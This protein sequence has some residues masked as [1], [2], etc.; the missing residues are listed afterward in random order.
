M[1]TLASVHRHLGN[2]GR[3]IAQAAT[4][5]SKLQAVLWATAGVSS[6]ALRPNFS[7][8][9]WGDRGAV[10]A[11]ARQGGQVQAACSLCSARG[12]GARACVPR[13]RVWAGG[14]GPGQE[15]RRGL[16]SKVRGVRPPA[17]SPRPPAA[18]SAPHFLPEVVQEIRARPGTPGR[19]ACSPGTGGAAIPG[20]VR[21]L[22]AA[23]GS[24]RVP[25]ILESNKH[26][27]GDRGPPGPV[28]G[29]ASAGPPGPPGPRARAD[30]GGLSPRPEWPEKLVTSGSQD[31]AK[32][33]GT[34]SG[35]GRPPR[36]VSPVPSPRA[37]GREDSGAGQRRRV[38][39][40][41]RRAR[42]A[43]LS[44]PQ[45]LRRHASTGTGSRSATSG[46]ARPGPR[47]PPPRHLP[48]P[49]SPAPTPL[50]F[51]PTW[52][53]GRRRPATPPGCR[54][55]PPSC[56]RGLQTAPR[57]PLRAPE[58]P[59]P[60]SAPWPRAPTR[61]RPGSPRPPPAPRTP[62][63]Q[64]RR[65][66]RVRH[67]AG[68]ARRPGPF[69][70]HPSP[71]LRPAPLREPR[72]S[73][74]TSPRDEGGRGARRRGDPDTQRS[75]DPGP[76]W[77]A[78]GPGAAGPG[79]G[80]RRG[81]APGVRAGWGGV[82]PRGEEAGRGGAGRGGA[83]RPRAALLAGKA[84]PAAAARAA[85]TRVPGAR[86][87]RLCSPPARRGPPSPQP[88]PHLPRRGAPPGLVARPGGLPAPP[89]HNSGAPPAATPNFASSPPVRANRT[90]SGHPSSERS[91]FGEG[92]G[93]AA[94][95]ASTSPAGA[96]E[97]PRSRRSGRSAASRTW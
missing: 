48:G 93:S 11:A 12:R 10:S 73:G 9:A 88:G 76:G 82:A 40:S 53:A 70:P 36:R 60:R 62:Y 25:S 87:G 13:S 64:P 33:A 95:A 49:P 90:P 34:V 59:E 43:R 65:A 56:P 21:A 85:S 30:R 24:R 31:G 67:V 79:G 17:D 50:S 74:G 91:P 58:P 46:R 20:R 35:A 27:L 47:A 96:G 26:G 3:N 86:S 78:G 28:P 55:T 61:P 37:A 5:P 52:P 38:P 14:R 2:L 41:P 57:G 97:D 22:G 29:H 32:G 4:Q 18:P 84:A 71:P 83:R 80:R 66:E 68:R 69:I 19:K 44:G 1:V 51:T 16:P 89:P 94:A 92:P 81:R 23:F 77:G 54:R 75:D 72:P 8:P 6:V 7:S 42:P 15:G 45:T 39:D 63:L